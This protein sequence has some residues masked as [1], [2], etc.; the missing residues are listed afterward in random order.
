MMIKPRYYPLAFVRVLFGVLV[1]FLLIS[2]SPAFA[3]H[4]VSQDGHLLDANPRL[5]SLG[6]NPDARLDALVPR[7]NNLYIT[8]NVSQGAGFQGLIP[9]RSFDEFSYGSGFDALN[10][11]R[12]D[13]VGGAD[14]SP[15]IISPQ[16]YLDSSRSITRLQG[17]SVVSTNELYE[18]RSEVSG[19][20]SSAPLGGFNLP[21]LRNPTQPDFSLRV[22]EP[23]TEDDDLRLFGIRTDFPLA[24]QEKPPWMAEGPAEEPPTLEPYPPLEQQALEPQEMM[25]QDLRLK[26]IEPL[27]PPSETNSLNLQAEPPDQ[28]AVSSA[29]P[30]GPARRD[31]SLSA[32]AEKPDAQAAAPTI[33][34]LV[35][36]ARQR[37]HE[38]MQ[39]GEKLMQQGDYYK[40]AY[41]FDSALLYHYNNAEAY[42]AK[43]HALFGAGEFM[44]AAFFLNKALLADPS[45]VRK[46]NTDLR[47]EFAQPEQFQKRLE[48]L[49]Y[50][51]ELSGQPLLSFLYGYVLFRIDNMEQAQTHLLKARQTQDLSKSVQILLDAVAQADKIKSNPDKTETKP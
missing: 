23:F 40:A 1:Q 27:M 9:Y 35:E 42:L 32:P 14:L 46:H 11:F 26:P 19:L 7:L 21:A 47:R 51:Q 44:S 15:D 5:G 3:Q 12:R 24:S 20:P 6:L 10:N 8:G 43:A 36:H 28:N 18:T 45:L 37:F 30:T 2:L 49:A 41:A 48:E 29:Y 13:S 38:H 4:Y 17:G 34:T 31:K 50:W 22:K 16:P 39:R 25:P 33:N